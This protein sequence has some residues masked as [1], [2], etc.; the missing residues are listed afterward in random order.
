MAHVSTELWRRWLDMWNGDLS[1]AD[2]IVAPSF[3]A[4]FAPVGPSP[5]AVRGPEGLKEWIGGV[6]EAFVDHRFA[7]T[8][9][10]LADADLL[11]GRWVFRAT[12]RGGLP[13]ASPAAVGTTVEYAGIDI[14][15]IE[16]GRLVEYWLCADILQLLQQVG[17]VPTGAPPALS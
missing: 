14:L 2:E 5:L 17:V 3:L 11:A 1:I 12:Y 10:P 13:G 7:T 16:E 15:R 9:G 6:L 8:V 4:H